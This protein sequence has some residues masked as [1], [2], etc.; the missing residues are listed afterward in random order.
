MYKVI[1]FELSFS[2]SAL[3]VSLAP[4]YCVIILCTCVCLSLN[5]LLVMVGLQINPRTPNSRQQPSIDATN[6]QKYNILLT[7]PTCDK[8]A[9]IFQ[10]TKEKVYKLTN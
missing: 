6:I 9:N 4:P 8:R 7:R 2:C 1:F 3:S 5:N 10:T